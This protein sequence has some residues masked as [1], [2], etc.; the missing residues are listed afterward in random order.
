MKKDH[1]KFFW[2]DIEIMK[3]QEDP[4][5]ITTYCLGKIATLMN[6]DSQKVVSLYDDF[7]D[8]DN[9]L[10]SYHMNKHPIKFWYNFLQN[11]YWKDLARVAI[12]IVSIIASEA[13]CE[14][15]FSVRR[16]IVSKHHTR[17]NNET[18]YY[19]AF[20]MVCK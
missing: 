12:R 17:M 15:M 7:I 5:S 3:Q 4:Y 11:S 9:D 19:R 13:G 18:A 14:R 16:N 1:S 10:M 6:L 8:Q 20:H 2:S